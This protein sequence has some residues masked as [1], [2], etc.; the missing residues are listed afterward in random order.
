MQS[1]GDV[2]L[3]LPDKLAVTAVDAESHELVG[4]VAKG[5]SELVA[6]TL[7]LMAER[8]K[9]AGSAWSQ[10]LHTLPE[11]T[12]SPIL[13]EDQVWL[14]LQWGGGVWRAARADIGGTGISHTGGSVAEA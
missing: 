9:G 6:L 13:W 12:A 3:E 4:P 2:L 1:T 11:T 14:C 10:L 5:C 8:A 7:W